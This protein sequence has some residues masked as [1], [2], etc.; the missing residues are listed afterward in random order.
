M[1]LALDIIDV[2]SIYHK[3]EHL[4][5]CI[6]NVSISVI[7]LGTIGLCL[8]LGIE[9]PQQ[10]RVL[11]VFNKQPFFSTWMIIIRKM[12]MMS[13]LI[14]LHHFHHKHNFHHYPSPHQMKMKPCKEK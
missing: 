10:T 6:Y 13:V 12:M 8:R 2:K 1:H 3:H 9:N 14:N 11:P 5:I 4:I 7:I